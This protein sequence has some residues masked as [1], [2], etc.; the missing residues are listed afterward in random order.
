[1]TSSR[2]SQPEDGSL[3]FNVAVVKQDLTRAAAGFARFLDHG[4]RK[5]LDENLTGRLDAV[6]Q[7][8][9]HKWE[10]P[11][12]SPLRTRPCGGAYQTTDSGMPAGA[13]NAYAELTFCWPVE[14]CD[15]QGQPHQ[16]RKP[17][18]HFRLTGSATTRVWLREGDPATA[19]G[20]SADQRLAMWRCETGDANSPGTYF[21][22][23]ILGQK[24]AAEDCFLFPTSL[25][26]P[27]LQTYF[28]LPQD[29]LSFVIG[30]LFQD[31]ARELVD[32]EFAAGQRDRF[33][34]ILDWQRGVIRDSAER[35]PWFAL[36]RSKPPRDLFL[37]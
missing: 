36:K 19:A 17:S 3:I 37:R 10:L 4:D 2:P 24:E 30:E 29:V 27:R 21:H 8:K 28:V 34:A 5:L 15:R 25:D 6:A 12:Y 18:T 23:Q 26:I 32:S 35:P 11:E 16:G 7:G 31:Q 14:R 33:G 9:L 13:H 22:T 20:C 1:M